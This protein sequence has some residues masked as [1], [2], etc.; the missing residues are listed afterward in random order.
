VGRAPGTGALGLKAFSEL[1]SVVETDKGVHLLKLT[2][3]QPGMNLS[4]ET[5]RPRIESRLSTERRTQSTETLVAKLKADAN[6]KINDE[7]LEKVDVGR[8]PGSEPPATTVERQ[9]ENAKILCRIRRN[10][11]LTP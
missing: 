2:A 3:R 9:R 11:S 7:V 8:D 10:R 5:V 6:V 1:S 4:F